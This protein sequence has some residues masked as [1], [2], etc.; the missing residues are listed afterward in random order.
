MPYEH[1]QW[2]VICDR[3]GMQ[4]KARQLR[5]EWNGLR[6]CFGKGTLGCWDPKHPRQELRP[7]PADRQ[8]PPWTRPEGEPRYVTGDLNDWDSL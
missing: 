4:Y 8:T 1:G 5:L 3:C 6:A 2:N 7:V